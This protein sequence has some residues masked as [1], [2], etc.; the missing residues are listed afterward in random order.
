MVSATTTDLETL[1]GPEKSPLSAGEGPLSTELGELL[2]VPS[3]GSSL[4]EDSS[5]TVNL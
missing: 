2:A 5:Y 4:M 3:L 1:E